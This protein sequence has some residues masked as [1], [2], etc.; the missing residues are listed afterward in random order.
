MYNPP[1]IWIEIANVTAREVPLTIHLTHHTSSSLDDPPADPDTV[2]MSVTP[3]ESQPTLA[4]KMPHKA[5]E[6]TELEVA[7]EEGLVSKR[8]FSLAR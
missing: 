2:T 8:H 3:Q 4:V 1:K 6:N 7:D 5:M